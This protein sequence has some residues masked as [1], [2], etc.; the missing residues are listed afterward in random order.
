MT[1]DDSTS[2]KSLLFGDIFTFGSIN[3]EESP[4]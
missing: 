1:I 4:G 3:N 2:E